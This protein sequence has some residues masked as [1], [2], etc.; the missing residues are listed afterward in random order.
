MAFRLYTEGAF[1]GLEETTRP[2]IQR[3]N[4]ASVVLQLKALGVEDVVG[5]DFMDRPPTASLLRALELLFALGAV[6]PDGRLAVPLG[7]D[8]ARLPV[9]PMFAKVLLLSGDMGCCLE[10]LGVVAMVS[11][12]NVFF[13]PRGKAEE[14]AEARRRFVCPYG[15]HTMMLQVFQAWMEVPQKE[16]TK[17]CRDHFINSRAMAKAADI[18]KQLKGYLDDLGV[19]MTSCKEDTTPVRRCLVA[20]LFPHAARRQPD[21]TYSLFATS[22]VVHLH[23]SSALCGKTPACIVF[24]ELVRTTKQYARSVAVVEPA[25]LVEMAPHFFAS[26]GDIKTALGPGS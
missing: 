8:M 10:A 21:G 20:G 16:R 17:W 4:L 7:E 24:N 5:F 13:T 11:A 23:P 6:G 3:I 25:W 18:Y 2:E 15:D 22:Q 9:D 1:Q 12:E 26:K 19:P 14:A